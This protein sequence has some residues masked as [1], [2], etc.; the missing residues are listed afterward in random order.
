MPR[1]VYTAAYGE[2][3]T[4]LVGLRK[5]AGMTQRELAE[6]LGREQNFVARVETGQRRVDMVEFVWLCEACGE[7][8]EAE[9]A[10]LTK[11]VIARLPRRR[12]KRSR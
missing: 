8:P 5:R 7:D 11:A 3:V 6:A 10:R 2:V 9:V 1:S 4:T 12:G